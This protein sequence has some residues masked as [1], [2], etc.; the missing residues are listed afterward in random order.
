MQTNLKASLDVQV[1]QAR[2]DELK[3]RV[4]QTIKAQTRNRR[5][6]DMIYLVG[7]A[8]Q[9]RLVKPYIDVNIS[10][11]ATVI[12]VY[13]SSRSHSANNDNS[14]NID[15]QGL[16]F[17]SMPWLLNSKEQ[18][19]TLATLNRQLWAKRS[20]SLS[21]IFAMGFDSYQLIKKIPLMQQAPYI[22]HYGQTGILQLAKSNILTRSLIWGR[23]YNEKVI[24]VVMD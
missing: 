15:L 18:D 6:I 8:A 14:T 22:R 13:A 2:I 16:T 5:D 17:T 10:P 11:F 21:S 9:T 3:S 24:Q 12:P 20:D 19:K 4:K 23:Y 1:S 7:S